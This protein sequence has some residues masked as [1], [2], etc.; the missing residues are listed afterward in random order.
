MRNLKA[1]G[2]R[3]TWPPMLVGPGRKGRWEEQRCI[4]PSKEAKGRRQRA[5]GRR[6]RGS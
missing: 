6:W 1:I 5:E 3:G 4:G 2:Y